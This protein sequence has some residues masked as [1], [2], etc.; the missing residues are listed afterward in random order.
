MDNGC[1]QWL[2]GFAGVANSGGGVY[3]YGTAFEIT[4]AGK[5]TTLHT[6][7]GSPD[8]WGPASGTRPSGIPTINHEIIV[9]AGFLTAPSTLY[10]QR[11]AF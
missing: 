4:P 2:C 10:T 1:L 9:S 8:G 3:G 7:S 11:Q 6:F 5:L